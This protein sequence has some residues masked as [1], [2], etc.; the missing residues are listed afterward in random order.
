MEAEK[1]ETGKEVNKNI[2]KYAGLPAPTAKFR[3]ILQPTRL[4]YNF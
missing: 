2:Y 3:T 1:K 4:N